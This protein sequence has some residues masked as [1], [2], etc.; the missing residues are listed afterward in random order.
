MVVGVHVVVMLLM[1]CSCCV[2]NL[3]RKVW[4]A[5]HV[6]GWMMCVSGWGVC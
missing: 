3:V 4:K 2:K 1:M 6:C 5:L